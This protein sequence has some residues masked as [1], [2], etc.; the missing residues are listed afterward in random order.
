MLR[1]IGGWP[2]YLM[3][4]ASGQVRYPKGTNRE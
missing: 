3:F 2:F 4:N 1:Q